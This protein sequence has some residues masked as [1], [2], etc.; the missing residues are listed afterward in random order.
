MPRFQMER[1]YIGR[2]LLIHL[3]L[4]VLPPGACRAELTELLVAWGVRITMAAIKRQEW[5]P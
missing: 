5:Q 1:F 4:R 2:W 3:V